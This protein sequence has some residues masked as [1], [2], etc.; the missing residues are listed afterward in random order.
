MVKTLL[1]CVFLFSLTALAQSNYAV[2]SGTIMDP[3]GHP[4]TGATVRLIA[5][6]TGAERH[7]GSN[8]QG[9]F[10][11][12]GLMPGDYT[13]EV[14]AA[15]FATLN[16]GLRL[17]VGQELSLNLT[18]KVATVQNVVEV[19]DQAPVL[20]TSDAAVGEVVEPVSIK[21]L[22]LNGRMLIDLVLTVPGAHESHGAQTGNMN[23]LY[24]R[25][26]QR[27]AV[28]I[29]GNRP[30]ANY[31]LLD[32]T[33]NTDPT[34]NTLNLSPSPDAVRELPLELGRNAQK[35]D[36]AFTGGRGAT[37][38]RDELDAEL[39]GEDLDRDVVERAL[40]AGHLTGEAPLQRRRHPDKDAL[41]VSF[42][43]SASSRTAASRLSPSAE[44]CANC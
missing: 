29:G 42:C 7:V 20:H 17:E 3:Q 18:L 40:A 36:A 6:N 28:S 34:F 2:L 12:P 31:Y 19:A 37:T 26:E 16:R 43:H 22:P 32:G 25:P 5:S 8:E 38:A 27:S 30:N 13:L 1:F 41:Q 11:V 23:P 33:T 24:W 44:L 21:E 10:Q 15:H 35:D 4:F 39:G 9:I 14:Q